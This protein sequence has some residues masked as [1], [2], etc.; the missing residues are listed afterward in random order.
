MERFPTEALF[1]AY[2]E[3]FAKYGRVTEGETKFSR[4]LFKIGGAPN[5]LSLLENFQNVLAR[6]GIDVEFSIKD[7]TT[8]SGANGRKRWGES[9]DGDSAYDD[10]A[11]GSE[12][13]DTEMST[14]PQRH[15]HVLSGRLCEALNIKGNEPLIHDYHDIYGEARPS[16]SNNGHRY[17]ERTFNDVDYPA[18]RELAF[19]DTAA[20]PDSAA[21]SEET[22]AGMREVLAL[23][24]YR[25]FRLLRIVDRWHGLAVQQREDNAGL[26]VIAHHKDRTV[27]LQSAIND[28]KAKLEVQQKATKGNDSDAA[29]A[30]RHIVRTKFYNAWKQLTIVS[31]AAAAKAESEARKLSQERRAAALRN[32]YFKQWREMIARRK[33]QEEAAQ[34]FYKAS[35]KRKVFGSRQP[36]VISVS[37][38]AADAR[39]NSDDAVRPMERVL[40]PGQS[41]IVATTSEEGKETSAYVHVTSPEV[42]TAHRDVYPKP[43]NS[44]VLSQHAQ[45]ALTVW[46]RRARQDDEASL[47]DRSKILREAWMIWQNQMRINIMSDGILA[48]VLVFCLHRLVFD[49]RAAAVVHKNKEELKRVTLNSWVSKANIVL[50]TQRNQEAAAQ[51]YVTK[52]RKEVYFVRLVSRMAEHERAEQAAI[53]YSRTQSMRGSLEKWEKMLDRTKDLH[54]WANEARFFFVATKSLKKW[55]DAAENSKKEKRRQAYAQVRRL[56]KMGLATDA[57]RKWRTKSQ[58]LLDSQQQGKEVQKNKSVVKAMDILDRWRAHV[59]ELGEMEVSAVRMQQQK[60]KNAWMDRLAAVRD[61]GVEAQGVYSEKRGKQAMRQWSLEVL[62]VRAKSNYADDILG[63][64]AKKVFRR[65]FSIWKMRTLE[66]EPPEPPLTAARTSRYAQSTFVPPDILPEETSEELVG[67]LPDI[68]FET[69]SKPPR[70]PS[71]TPAAPLSTASESRLRA[72]FVSS[73]RSARRNTRRML[74]GSL[75]DGL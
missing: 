58:A 13:M 67:E 24:H 64:N 30:R 60:A 27:L 36:R 51:L 28:W 29:L 19:T 66:Q 56:Q 73:N 72:Q 34:A 42:A 20:Y 40:V 18:T 38:G 70:L 49:A 31:K 11:R 57:I 50:S 37:N 1:I 75:R 6:M 33:A 16:P 62:K 14:Q 71:T 15:V 5:D 47:I 55:K 7:G 54:K 74:G 2:H 23:R 59:E 35:L 45:P 17:E 43:K 52:K 53:D 61:L 41:E 26:A 3:L 8:R 12:A 25:R 48:R 4:V 39:V 10:G 9:Q 65:S 32:K 22:I 46:R 63:K 44:F 69:P 68:D 21:P